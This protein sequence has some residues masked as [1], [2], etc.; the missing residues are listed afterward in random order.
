MPVIAKG[1]VLSQ[2]LSH[3]GSPLSLR[4]RMRLITNCGWL[5]FLKLHNIDLI[6]VCLRFV[7]ELLDPT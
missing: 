4:R 2:G 7:L 6:N 1:T 3:R 5:R